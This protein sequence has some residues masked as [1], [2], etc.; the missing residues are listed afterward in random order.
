MF[1]NQL[2]HSVY[3]LVKHFLEC[4]PDVNFSIPGGVYTAVSVI[5][6]YGSYF[7]PIKQLAPILVIEFSLINFSI[8]VNVFKFYKNNL[9]V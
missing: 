4:L 1:W 6:H 8:F 5:V 3:M 9:R 7:V 2:Y